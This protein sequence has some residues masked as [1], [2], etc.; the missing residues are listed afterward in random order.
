MGRTLMRGAIT[1]NLGV[2]EKDE[3]GW[4]RA[5]VQSAS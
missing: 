1:G 2:V 5:V 4:E 3:K